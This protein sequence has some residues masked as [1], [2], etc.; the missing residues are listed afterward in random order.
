MVADFIINA[1]HN[2][3]ISGILLPGFLCDSA[4]IMLVFDVSTQSTVKEDV[5][6]FGKRLK[7]VLSVRKSKKGPP[8]QDIAD[9]RS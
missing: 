9:V 4:S 8:K 6:D 3:I 2:C 5:K 7:S 1:S